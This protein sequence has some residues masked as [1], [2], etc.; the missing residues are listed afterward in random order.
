MR[1]IIKDRL[2]GS[3][4]RALAFQSDTKPPLANAMHFKMNS[5]GTTLLYDDATQLFALSNTFSQ[6][7][8]P[9]HDGKLKLQTQCS[10]VN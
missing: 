4:G 2:A 1:T 10:A 9:L 3:V 5:F 8:F 6:L 7:G